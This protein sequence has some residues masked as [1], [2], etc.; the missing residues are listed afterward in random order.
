MKAGMKRSG[1]TTPGPRGSAA[2]EHHAVNQLSRF[3]I[4]RRLGMGGTPA[5]LLS[6]RA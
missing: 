3:S 2:P 5:R 1:A 4:L 6:S